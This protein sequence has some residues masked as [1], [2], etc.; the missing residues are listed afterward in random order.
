MPVDPTLL[1]AYLQERKRRPAIVRA[2]NGLPGLFHYTIARREDGYE[3]VLD[4]DGLAHVWRMRN[5]PSAEPGSRRVAYETN[6]DPDGDAHRSAPPWDA[7]RWSP[8]GAGEPA[9]EIA[10]GWLRLTLRGRKLSGEFSLVKLHDRR[11]PGAW[12]FAAARTR[13]ARRSL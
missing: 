6:G 10:D 2:R 3:L 9:Q 12:L 4:V 11:R 5:A 7:G 8:A 1:A 13:A